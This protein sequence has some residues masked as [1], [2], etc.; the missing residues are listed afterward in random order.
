MIKTFSELHNNGR[1][2]AWNSKIDLKVKHACWSSTVHCVLLSRFKI[3]FI[4]PLGS[5]FIGKIFS[6]TCQKSTA[7][8]YLSISLRFF[9]L[10]SLLSMSNGHYLVKHQFEVKYNQRK[11]KRMAKESLKIVICESISLKHIFLCCSTLNTPNE[12]PNG[13]TYI[14]LT[15]A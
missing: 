13:E 3:H 9:S 1:K 6:Q 8:T 4:N 5:L 15:C 7:N 10:S 2:R 14:K 11:K 12:S